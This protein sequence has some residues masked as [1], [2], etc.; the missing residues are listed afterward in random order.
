MERKFADHLI[1]KFMYAQCGSG[2]WHVSG[3]TRMQSGN[4]NV[5]QIVTNGEQ[6]L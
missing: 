5:K 2:R 3:L 6:N 4:N 1:I